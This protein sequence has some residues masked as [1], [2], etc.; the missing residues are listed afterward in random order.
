MLN[1]ALM[2]I[3]S[4]SVFQPTLVSSRLPQAPLT[5]FLTAFISSSS[6][7]PPRL[8]A[9]PTERRQALQGPAVRVHPAG[10]PP[11]PT[12]ARWPAARLGPP[13]EHRQPP[14]VCTPH[15]ENHVHTLAESARLLHLCPAA[16]VHRRLRPLQAGT[17][18]QRGGAG[19][20]RLTYFTHPILPW[21]SN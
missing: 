2:L 3:H 19:D 10:I 1:C 16:P 9:P 14:Q 17:R 13:Q 5:C 20:V 8:F 6:A 21:R 15:Q 11:L 12:Q 7:A 18:L 4:S